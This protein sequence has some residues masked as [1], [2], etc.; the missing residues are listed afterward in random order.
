VPGA[1]TSKPVTFK[2]DPS[3]VLDYQ[4]N[5]ATWLDGDSILGSSWIVPS[6]LT[7]VSS[8]H[9]ATTA[10]IWLSGGMLISYEVTNRIV[11]AGGRTDDR[12]IIIKVEQR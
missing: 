2:K 8:S 9:T 7:E 11:T 6:D 3:A 12:T 4:I 5:W 10:T 1:S